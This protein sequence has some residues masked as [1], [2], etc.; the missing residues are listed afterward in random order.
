MTIPV[1]GH[2]KVW[3]LKLKSEPFETLRSDLVKS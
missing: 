2:L 1:S 3:S